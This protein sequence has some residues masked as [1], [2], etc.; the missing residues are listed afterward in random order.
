M[1]TETTN[2]QS[3]PRHG[4]G[5]RGRM[6]GEKARDFRGT[7]IKLIKYLSVYRNSILIVVLFAAIS[8]VFTIIGPKILGQAITKLF[9]GSIAQLT[10]TGSID[11]DA[12]GK[13]LLTVAGLYLTSA[14]FSYGQGWIMAGVS[15]KI[16]YR[17]RK[18]IA[19]KINRMPL[20]YFE[21][22]NH[23]EI[24]SRVTNDVDTVSHTL[25]QSLSQ[26]I[27]SSITVIGVLIMMLSISWLMT[28]VALAII[29]LSLLVVS[30][31]VKQ[32]QKYFKQ[33]QDY[34]GHV[35][36]HVEEMYGGH[37]VIKA[38]NGEE[39]S[40]QRFNQLNDKLYEAAWKSQFFSGMM[41]PIINF[42]GNIGYVAVCILGGYLAVQ[43]TITVGDIQAFIQYVRN[44]T[45]PITQLA[46]ISNVLQQTAAAAERVFEFLNEA[47]ESPETENP[48]DPETVRDRVEFK[49]VRFGYNPQKIIIKNFSA[50]VDSGQKIAI[51]G[52]TGAGKT[53]I[54]KLLMRF[55]DVTDGAILI[56]EH[57]VKD[58]Y[59]K[60]LR[61]MFGMVLQDTWMF[62]GT[63]ID[64]IRYGRPDVS[65]EEVIA[66]A[67]AAHIDH[68]I[69]TLP[70]GYNFVLN[71]ETTNISQGQMQLL[72][73]ARAILANPK[74]LI[75]DEATSSVDTRTE[76][77]I[78]KAM[79]HLMAN[80]TSFIIAHR[81]STIRD[82]D[83]I[84]VM[85]DG[86]I[87]EQG[88]HKELLARGGFYAELYNSQFEMGQTI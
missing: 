63:I 16:T 7:M 46:N 45:Q 76:L 6:T 60:D 80:R 29:P 8:T 68:F 79:D 14:A 78:Q 73:I 52:P 59:R 84:L 5:R 62:N 38:F 42:I 58:F 70:E 66:A 44:F 32:S 34:L 18:D 15:A 13:I 39:K 48:V 74:M 67:K 23:G 3:M 55:Y 53:T 31:I 85:R 9:E 82:A 71:E 69:R 28:L 12:I 30:L 19:E 77:L 1:N 4:G 17:F 41:M 56:D 40:I 64:N 33:Q 72:T 49:N 51:V 22:T 87:V 21:S 86:D 65:D 57:N 47:E 83:L 81:L 2:R 11:F 61:Q 20:G 54:V 10:G 27:T 88:K 50:N 25:N 43:K 37:I 35:N 75:L 26:I 24:L 36:G